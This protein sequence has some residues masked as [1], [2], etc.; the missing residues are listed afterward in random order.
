MKSNIFARG[1][2]YYDAVT[3]FEELGFVCKE[4]PTAT[5]AMCLNYDERMAFRVNQLEDTDLDGVPDGEDCDPYD[6]MFQDMIGAPK[7]NPNVGDRKHTLH[8][9]YLDDYYWSNG[10]WRVRPDAKP[11]FKRRWF[12]RH[13]R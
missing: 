10:E 13:K 5:S 12:R 9:F 3:L 7:L 8:G 6:P 11:A 2:D 1:R 4:N